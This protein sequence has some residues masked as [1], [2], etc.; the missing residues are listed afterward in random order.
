M[1]KVIPPQNVTKSVGESATFI[2]RVPNDDTAKIR[3]LYKKMPHDSN[4]MRGT[5][6]DAVV[7]C[8]RLD[9]QSMKYKS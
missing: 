4:S 8:L 5:P 7:S 2:C 6:Q 3:W 1:L 9:F